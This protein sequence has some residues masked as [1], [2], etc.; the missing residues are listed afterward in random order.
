ML[1]LWMGLLVLSGVFFVDVDV[2]MF[3]E[4]GV[5]GVKMEVVIVVG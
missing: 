4:N 2:W 3:V 1:E 5:E